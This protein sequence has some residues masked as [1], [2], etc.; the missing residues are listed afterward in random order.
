[1][2]C[3]KILTALF[4]CFI[5]YFP[6]LT[7][8]SDK[9]NSYLRID[10][11]EAI[12]LHCKMNHEFYCNPYAIVEFKFSSVSKST[13]KVECTK[14]PSWESSFTFEPD[15]CKDVVYINFYQYLTPRDHAFLGNSVISMERFEKGETKP[16][17]L[18]RVVLELE[19]LPFGEVEDWFMVES[20]VENNRIMFPSCVHL[21]IYYTSS[22]CSENSEK[23]LYQ[24]NSRNPDVENFSPRNFISM[25]KKDFTKIY[26]SKFSKLD[27][28]S[29]IKPISELAQIEPS[30]ACTEDPNQDYGFL[31]K[32]S[33][34][35][36]IEEALVF[37]IIR[38]TTG[39]E[40][41]YEE[42]TS[43]YWKDR[44]NHQ[45]SIKS[46]REFFEKDCYKKMDLTIER[47]NYLLRNDATEFPKNTTNPYVNED[48][49]KLEYSQKLN[50]N[51]MQTVYSTT[52]DQFLTVEQSKALVNNIDDE[53]YVKTVSK[54]F[55]SI[56]EMNAENKTDITMFQTKNKVMLTNTG[57]VDPRE[58]LFFRIFALYK[59]NGGH[60][61]YD[62]LKR[63][64]MLRKKY[65]FCYEIVKV[66]PTNII[67]QFIE[68]TCP[69]NYV[70]VDPN[71][72]IVQSTG[73]DP[74]L[75]FKNEIE[76]NG[77]NFFTNFKNDNNNEDDSNSKMPKTTSLR[78]VSIKT[79]IAE[80]QNPI[81]KK[82]TSSPIKR[83]PNRKP[84]KKPQNEDKN[85]LES[86]IVDFNQLLKME[87]NMKV[88][89]N[90]E[91]IL[92]A[93]EQYTY[94]NKF[95]K[96][97][98]QR[99][100]RIKKKKEIII[101]K[102]FNHVPLLGEVLALSNQEKLSDNINTEFLKRESNL[103][104]KYLLMY[105]SKIPFVAQ[106][107]HVLLDLILCNTDKNKVRFVLNEML[108][109]L[110]YGDDRSLKIFEEIVRTVLLDSL[111]SK[112][113]FYFNDLQSKINLAK[114]LN[115]PFCYKTITKIRFVEQMLM[116]DIVKEKITYII[117]NNDT[118]RKID[119]RIAETESSIPLTLPDSKRLFSYLPGKEFDNAKDIN[120][121]YIRELE[122]IDK[123]DGNDEVFLEIKNNS[124]KNLLGKDFKFKSKS[125]PGKTSEDLMDQIKTMRAKLN[126][127]LNIDEEEMEN[128]IDI[129]AGDEIKENG[130]TML[131]NIDDDRE[132][133]NLKTNMTE[134]KNSTTPEG[135][136][137]MRE[138]KMFE[139]N[140]PNILN[141]KKISELLSTSKEMLK[142]IGEKFNVSE[143][144]INSLENKN[145]TISY[146]KKIEE[147][148]FKAVSSSASQTKK[149]QDDSLQQDSDNVN[150]YSSE[151]FSK[152]SLHQ[153]NNPNIY[154]RHEDSSPKLVQPGPT[155]QPS[156]Q[157]ILEKIMKDPQTKGIIE[158]TKTT[159]PDNKIL[160]PKEIHSRYEVKRQ[161]TKQ[162]TIN[163]DNPTKKLILGKL[164]DEGTFNDMMDQDEKNCVDDQTGLFNVLKNIQNKKCSCDQLCIEIGTIYGPFD[165]LRP[166]N[167]TIMTT[168]DENVHVIIKPVIVVN[169]TIERVPV[170]VPVNPQPEVIQHN[171]TS[172][173]EDEDCDILKMSVQKETSL[174]SK[175]MRFKELVTRSK[176]LQPIKRKFYRKVEFGNEILA[177]EIFKQGLNVIILKREK[178]YSKV[179]ER[180]FNTNVDP[181]DSDAM[182][183]IL[184]DAGYD[185][186]IV[187]TGIG[188]WMGAITPRL[189]KEIKQIGGPDLNRLVSVDSEDNSMADHAFILVGRRGLCRYNG[190]FKVKNY[191][192]TRELKRYF[193]DISSDPNDCYFENLTYENEKNKHSENQFF[194]LVDLRMVLNLSND[195]RF[196]YLAP[197]ITSVSPAVGPLNGGQVIRI[198]GT[199][200]GT[201]LLDIKEI[202]VRGV[203]CRDVMWVNPNLITCT[204]GSSSIM[205]PGVGNVQIKLLCGLSSP[206]NTC[207][208]FQYSNEIKEV[209]VPVPK[210]FIPPPMHVMTTQHLLPLIPSPGPMIPAPR[211]VFQQQKIEIKQPIDNTML[212]LNDGQIT[213]YSPSNTS[214]DSF[215]QNNMDMFSFKQKNSNRIK[216]FQNDSMNPS[217]SDI[218]S[219]LNRRLYTPPNSI[220]VNKIDNLVTD[221]FQNLISH[222]ENNGF[223]RSKDGFR[224]RRFQ[225]IID[226]LK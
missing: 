211:P 205:G 110:C 152:L 200:F 26:K 155:P 45:K 161:G 118:N 15:V 221:N 9:F 33:N 98:F 27:S 60:L 141:D 61:N 58:E 24:L 194:H 171:I 154:E 32:K 41:N 136:D 135:E 223:S 121:N 4:F 159:N 19:K 34:L 30:K 108:E 140:N 157:D 28:E 222:S 114:A 137:L 160:F 208:M 35:T 178:G 199:N 163:K 212:R 79:R 84:A 193:P 197:L 39:E 51:R 71:G 186:I 16:G 203:V 99:Q 145:S 133:Q 210:V 25:C 11:V 215:A 100:A 188:K 82:E 22:T 21:R 185:K 189:I 5:L 44:N 2:K 138:F 87:E 62:D 214:N 195:N 213:D 46:Y 37:K 174:Y 83:L 14:N 217:I 112:P 106:A 206:T 42:F 57:L 153:Y 77:I 130:K 101:N 52:L 128:E 116:L 59:W 113:Y 167:V 88:L 144:T 74:R 129:K 219:N 13:K 162:I 48:Q 190:V 150:N 105:N 143:K 92:N 126:K 17:F 164:M 148:K 165:S 70:C 175:N 204:T 67:F 75:V 89:D 139:E 69:D 78:F 198:R 226:Q 220:N 12:N 80:K 23:Q 173:F 149:K 36:S 93:E 166:K 47:I 111:L 120:K 1:M 168:K 96:L 76:K 31:H 180:T 201:S 151:D 184:R 56:Q 66:M 81:L 86:E 107:A 72:I 102:V 65:F 146:P 125:Q 103:H 68:E 225:K 156:Q 8:T 119:L 182:A 181:V 202:L 169:N 109:G 40:I 20:P 123:D 18:G 207:N 73:R 49:T 147:F 192:I 91:S 64:Y 179:F 117:W 132:I 97:Y 172:L 104:K 170:P 187:V 54:M 63:E 134:L 131:V 218:K 177:T 216:Q 53:T 183:C 50:K 122:K 29:S 209:V 55:Q 85:E 6:Q 7:N 127:D 90:D 224:K 3:L 158:S 38:R 196:S 10:V 124:N 94:M 191:D 115:K 43:D 142:S 95:D 176:H